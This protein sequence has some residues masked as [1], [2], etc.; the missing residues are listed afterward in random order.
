MFLSMVHCN[1]VH[2]RAVSI[3]SGI[4]VP[5]A[6]RSE[7]HNEQIINPHKITMTFWNLSIIEYYSIHEGKSFHY[8]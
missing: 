2:C 5:E 7:C 1:T 6:I 8:L 4:P 3:I